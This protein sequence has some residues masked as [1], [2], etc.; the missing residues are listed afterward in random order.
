MAG[1]SVTVVTLSLTLKKYRPPA[2]KSL[3]D[4]K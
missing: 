4:R 1:S 2:E 3:T